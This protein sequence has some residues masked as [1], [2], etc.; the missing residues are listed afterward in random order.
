MISIEEVASRGF[1]FLSVDG[2]TCPIEEPWLWS[3]DNSAHMLGGKAGV[4]YEIG[5][6]ICKS[7]MAWIHGPLP[8]GKQSDIS[9]FRDELRKQIPVGRR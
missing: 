5:L 6:S 9:N 7:K 3:K 1:I 4:D 2:T 8:S